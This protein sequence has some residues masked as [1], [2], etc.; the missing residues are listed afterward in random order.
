MGVNV[1]YIKLSI[2][3]RL[4]DEMPG[5]LSNPKMLGLKPLVLQDIFCNTVMKP[6]NANIKDMLSADFK[7]ELLRTVLFGRSTIH[8]FNVVSKKLVVK[9]RTR[10]PM[11]SSRTHPPC[12]MVLSRTTS[13]GLS[14]LALSSV[15]HKMLSLTRAL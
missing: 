5:L 4:T 1:N 7:Y 3:G 6:E 8:F 9:C 11:Y 14:S 2:N 15:P 10:R 13:A 12:S